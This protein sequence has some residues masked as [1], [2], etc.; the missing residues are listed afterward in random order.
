MRQTCK[1]CKSKQFW[2]LNDGRLKCKRCYD[3][4]TPDKNLIKISRKLLKQ[5]ISEFV[6][7]HSTNT[8]LERVDISKYKLLKILTVLRIEMTKDVPEMFSGIVEVDETY[9]GG[10]WKNK[11]L[12]VKKDAL[13]KGKNSKKGRG[14][15]KQPVFGILCRNGTVWAELISGIEKKDLQPRIEKRVEKGSTVCSDTWRGYTGIAQ[16]GYVHRLVN[17]SKNEYSDCKG[18][19]IN[20]LE[21]FWGYMKR[22]LSA[23][24]GIRKE[25]LHLFVGEYV[26]KY[27]HRNLNFKEREKLLFKLIIKHFRSE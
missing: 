17:H 6:L 26:W 7:E 22:K 5:I 24:G 9:L 11:R 18:N 10:Q 12:S 16:K 3:K 20:G 21:G 15:S 8:I 27:N 19:H 2:R 13:I 23:R 14:T 4:F 1:K 25:K